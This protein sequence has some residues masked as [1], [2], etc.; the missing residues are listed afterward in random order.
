[1]KTL[2]MA[3]KYPGVEDAEYEDVHVAQPYFFPKVIVSNDGSSVEIVE[4][5]LLGDEDIINSIDDRD[6]IPAPAPYPMPHTAEDPKRY[7]GIG[8]LIAFGSGIL[9][10][11]FVAYLLWRP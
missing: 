2:D 7:P 5:E 9:F 8:L 1:M 6:T 11:G 3:D 10:W 4:G